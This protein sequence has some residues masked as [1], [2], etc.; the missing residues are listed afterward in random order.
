MPDAADWK[1]VKLD[2]LN[3]CNLP[4]TLK[5]CPTPTPPETTNVPVVGDVD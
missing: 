4:P 2:P 1:A 5:V 3:K